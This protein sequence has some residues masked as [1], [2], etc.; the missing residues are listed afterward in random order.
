M[1][2]IADTRSQKLVSSIHQRTLQKR[3][4]HMT[5][6]DWSKALYPHHQGRCQT[7]S[8]G[9]DT[10]G[11]SFATRGAVNGLCSTFTKRPTPVASCQWSV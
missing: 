2:H 7:F 8:F 1:A 4:L 5:N 3:C 9:G 11:A 6:I 10:G